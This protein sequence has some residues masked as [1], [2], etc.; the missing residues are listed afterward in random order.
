MRFYWKFVFATISVF[1][2][3]LFLFSLV[4]CKG[5][6][7]EDLVCGKAVQVASS[8]VDIEICQLFLISFYSL[9]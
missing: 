9:S 3:C 4:G 5:P 6:L 2:I 8:K 7:K 1:I